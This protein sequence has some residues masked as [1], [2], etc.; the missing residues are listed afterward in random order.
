MKGWHH[1]M[2]ASPASPACAAGRSSIKSETVNKNVKMVTA[3][4]SNKSRG[5]F[6][7]R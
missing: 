6:I 1:T 2:K 4:A 7:S 5:I 3:V